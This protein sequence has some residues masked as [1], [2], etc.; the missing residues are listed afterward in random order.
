[1]NNAAFFCTQI[2]K[3]LDDMKLMKYSPLA[4]MLTGLLTGCLGDSGAGSTNSTFPYSFNLDVI[5]AGTTKAKQMTLNWTSASNNSG[6]TYSVCEKDTTK[7]NNCKVLTSVTDA[8]TA[9]ITVDS[10]VKALSTDY[11]ILA[12]SGNSTKAS[13]EVSLTTDTVTRMIGYFKASNT[14]ADD[15]FGHSLALSADGNILAVGA[16]GE[17]NGMKG[18]ITNGS[19]TTDSGTETD[20]G[21]VYLFSK[22]AGRWTQIAYIKASNAGANDKFG[23]SVALSADG[24]ILAVGASG[25]DNGVKGVITNGSESSDSSTETDSG[26]V[27]LFSN[28]SGNWVQTAYIKGSNAGANDE[29]G[30]SVAISAD[31]STLAI[32]ASGESNGAKGIITNGTETTDNGSAFASGAVYLFNNNSGR[33]SQSA[34]VKASNTGAN[35]NFGYRIALS[36]DGTNMAVSTPYESNGAKGVITDG[37]E[38]TDSGTQTYSGAAYL[39]SKTSGNW[40][41]TAYVKASNTGSSDGFGVGLAL[42]ADGNTLAVGAKYEDNGAYGIITDGSEVTDSGSQTDSGAVYL[43]SNA[44]GSWAQSAYIKASNSAR[45]SSFGYDVAFSADSSTLAVA[46]VAEGIEESGVIIDGLE[47]LV[48]NPKN[49]SGAVYLFNNDSGRWTQNA[50]IKASNTGA[51]DNFGWRVALS[52]DGST[53][54]TSAIG[55]DN[56]AKGIITDGSEITSD[57]GSADGSGAV[58]IY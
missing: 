27:Y 39:F 5:S 7:T 19:E 26:A 51:S 6:V 1:M 45:G 28:T 57:T 44:S 11:F 8:L 46:A 3:L 34:Y 54:A 30:S 50:Y 12:S 22:A 15:D 41:Q 56:G 23:L 47:T 36:A 58:Y 33:W 18:I 10:L 25:E 14:E 29:F 43:F 52:S 32:G 16:P 40:A 37:S 2:T 35:D 24:S 55:E 21:A 13:N 38:V 53:L 48:Y 31:G 17:D 49:I 9:T 4:L 42:S 20:S